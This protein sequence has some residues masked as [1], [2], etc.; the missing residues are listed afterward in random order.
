MND[1]Y[2]GKD[3]MLD[4]LIINSERLNIKHKT[5]IKFGSGLSLKKNTIMLQKI[6]K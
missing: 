2:L 4:L 1:N 5:R 3:W 6:K